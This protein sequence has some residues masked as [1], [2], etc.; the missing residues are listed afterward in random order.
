[1]RS[2]CQP[3]AM[4]TSR[5][6]MTSRNQIG[7]EAKAGPE[8]KVKAGAPDTTVDSGGDGASAGTGDTGSDSVDKEPLVAD[9]MGGIAVHYGRFQMNYSVIYRTREFKQQDDNHT[10]G[11]V[12]VTY[13]Y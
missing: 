9:L 13:M 8:L 2:R 5:A 10:F 11:A 12:S 1:M 3:V 4:V 7:I 6:R